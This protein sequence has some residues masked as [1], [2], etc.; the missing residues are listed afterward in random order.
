MARWQSATDTIPLAT[1]LP[2]LPFADSEATDVSRLYPRASVFTGAKATARNFLTARLPV[3]HF[4]GHTIVNPEFPFLSR[5]LFAPDSDGEDHS[6]VLLASAV[7]GHRFLDTR[8]MV[9]ASCESAAGKFIHGEGVDSVARM[10]LD[11]GVPSVVASL[12]PVDDDQ[13]PLFMEFHRQLRAGLDAAQALRAAQIR[14]I[15][16][17][18]GRGSIRRWAG[19][20][21]IG[22]MNVGGSERT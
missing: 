22:G 16:Q 14:M 11:A 13:T 12:W 20:V 1:G 8:V 4:A 3:I 6:G 5:L 10:F 7:A 17:Q 15:G 18:G 21:A 2:R 19:F 9:L